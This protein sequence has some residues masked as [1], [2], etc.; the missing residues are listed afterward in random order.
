M[1]SSIEF[2]EEDEGRPSLGGGLPSS[3]DVRDTTGTFR[4]PFEPG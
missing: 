3:S 4:L 1:L 2:M